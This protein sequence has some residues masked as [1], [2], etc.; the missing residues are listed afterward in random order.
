L[1]QS[2]HNLQNSV[3]IKSTEQ[4]GVSFCS[5]NASVVETSLLLRL[6]SKLARLPEFVGNRLLTLIHLVKN[7]LKLILSA[8]V[9]YSPQNRVNILDPLLEVVNLDP[10]QSFLFL[11]QV[12]IRILKESQSNV[13]LR[14]YEADLS[15]LDPHE[16][17]I[18]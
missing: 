9:L 10:G 5:Q 15:V 4:L 8:L 7:L 11:N 12:V 2:G 18:V 3:R 13:D 6:E 1:K 17:V 14:L 16:L